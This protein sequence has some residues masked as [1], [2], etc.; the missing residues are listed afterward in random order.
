MIDIT[1]IDDI[2]EVTETEMLGIKKLDTHEYMLQVS[3]KMGFMAKLNKNGSI[4]FSFDG[5]HRGSSKITYYYIIEEKYRRDWKL[6]DLRHGTSTSWVRLE[7]PYGFEL[8]IN[9]VA[10][11]EI[12]SKITIVNGRFVTPC[13]FQAKMRNAKL[14]VEKDNSQDFFYSLIKAVSDDKDLINRLKDIIENERPDKV[15]SVLT[16]VIH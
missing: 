14:L 5:W 1:N 15:Y 8:E 3:G 11:K 4:P 13:Y 2:R 9:A 7:H 12:A 10:F 6:K 16:S